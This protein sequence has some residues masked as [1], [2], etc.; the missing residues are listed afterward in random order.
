M[1]TIQHGNKENRVTEILKQN[2]MAV[3]QK[4][5]LGL[6]TRDVNMPMVKNQIKGKQPLGLRQKDN[7]DKENIENVKNKENILKDQKAKSEND[8]FK[9]IVNPIVPCNQFKAFKVYEDENYTERLARIDEKLKNK[10][11]HSNLQVYKGTTEDSKYYTKNEIAEL[12]RK[13]EEESS[14]SILENT[15]KIESAKNIILDNQ[16]LDIS[17]E[18]K[19]GKDAILV[20]EKRLKT[21]FFELEEY[22]S[23]IYLY[24]R[25]HELRHRPKPGYMKKQPDVTSN[26]RTILVDWLVEVAEEYKLHTETLY[27][28]VNYIDRFLSYMSVVRAK[29]QL[30]GTAAMF[31]ASKYEEIYPPEITEFV[32]ITDDTYNKRQVIRMEHLILKVLGFDLSV[33][34]P[35]TFITAMCVSNKLSDKTMYLAMYFSELSLLNGDIYLEFVPSVL[36]ASAIALARHTLNEEPWNSGLVETTGYELKQLEAGIEFLNQMFTAA[37]SL[38]QHAIQDKYKSKKCMHVSTLKP[39]ELPINFT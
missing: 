14:N 12:E 16:I 22:R 24:L 27:L 39:R 4:R 18:E 36:A 13:S 9:N 8:N 10:A 11:K 19:N 5:P 15:S 26:M 20:G 30:V 2:A 29:L 35:L 1:E 6:S 31:L 3:R 21:L 38:P 25:E 32:Y 37:P 28:A 33:P 34:T 23:D 17:I 7:L